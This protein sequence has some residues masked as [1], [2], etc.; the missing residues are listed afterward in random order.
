MSATKSELPGWFNPEQALE[1]VERHTKTC[2]SFIPDSRLRGV[3]EIM[4]TAG[5][6]FGRAQVSAGRAWNEAV[7]RAFQI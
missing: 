4:T 7:K 3:A 2:T 1:Q 6:E 5:F